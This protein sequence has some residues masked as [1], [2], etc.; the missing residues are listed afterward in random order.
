M[1]SRFSITKPCCISSEYKVVQPA[2]KADEIILESNGCNKYL[3]KMKSA[4][5]ITDSFS[6]WTKEALVNSVTN[7]T[8]TLRSNLYFLRQTF[9]HSKITWGLTKGTFCKSDEAISFLR[10]SFKSRR[11]S[12]MLLSIKK[13]SLISLVPIKFKITHVNL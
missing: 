9:K 4:F 10:L 8:A 1:V 7:C 12:A 13:L 2:S 11:Y 3:L 6:A 5:V